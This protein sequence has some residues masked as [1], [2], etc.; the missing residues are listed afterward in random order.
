[1]KTAILAGIL[2][3]VQACATNT[4]VSQNAGQTHS[5][6]PVE[7]Q[8]GPTPVPKMSEPEPAK[9]YDFEVMDSQGLV[10]ATDRLYEKGNFARI[11]N[12]DGSVWFEFTFYT[13]SPREFS[14]EKE[15]FAPFVNDT[16]EKVVL[17]C[18]GV[19]G[20]YF[21]VLVNEE[22]RLEKFVKRNDPAFEFKTW[23]QYVLECFAVNFDAR[24]NPI[25]TKP[26][27]EIVD[28]D[29]TADTNYHPD[30]IVG[31]WLRI[32]WHDGNDAQQKPRFG[33]IKWKEGNR[34]L[35]WYFEMA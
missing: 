28:H 31:N 12:K 20:Q 17:K 10:A 5:V 29:V 11:Y 1:M 26:N 23:G 3:T 6:R 4:T 30:R 35:I 21:R 14:I 34:L 22:T 9:Q 2:L 8:A 27:G 15:G 18:I 33:W 7:S 19:S 16:E 25:R 13:E 24:Q 32:R